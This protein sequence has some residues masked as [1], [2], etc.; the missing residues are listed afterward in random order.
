M[1]LSHP[2]CAPAGRGSRRSAFTL[3]E[4]LVVIAIIAVLISLLLP[5]VQKA[6]EAA[7]RAQCANNL[8]QIGLGIHNY[9]S[10]ADVFPYASTSDTSYSVFTILLPYLEQDVIARKYNPKLG[11]TDDTTLAT[12]GYSNFS[13]GKGGVPTYLCPSMSKPTVTSATMTTFSSY[14]VSSGTKFG[15]S[16]LYPDGEVK[17]GVIIGGPQDGI[18]VSDKYSSVKVSDVRDG[19]ANTI[20]TGESDY[21]LN[22]WSAQ[23]TASWPYGYAGYSYA[24]AFVPMNIHQYYSSTS[25][26]PADCSNYRLCSGIFG[27]RSQH[28]NGVNFGFGDGSVRFLRDTISFA[29]YQALNTRDGGEILAA[30]SY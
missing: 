10:A 12:L 6:R 2:R 27:F 16:H 11:P 9:Y 30:G 23:G 26:L 5:A 21:K 7:S 18:I 17:D 25:T 19:T 29:T 4:L 24:S 20:M 14:L 3:I 1:R 13:L 8:R 28:P 15:Y 22:G